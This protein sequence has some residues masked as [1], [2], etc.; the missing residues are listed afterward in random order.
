MKLIDP[1]ESRSAA[2]GR[3]AILHGVA[4]AVAGLAGLTNGRYELSGFV[5]LGSAVLI[6]WGLWRRRQS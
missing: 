2:I 3:F 5:F 4:L 6:G 1:D